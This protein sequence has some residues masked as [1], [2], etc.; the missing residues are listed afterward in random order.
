MNIMKTCVYPGSFDPVTYGHLDIIVRAAKTFDK[1]IV[2]VGVNSSKKY[3]FS[4]QQ[5]IDMLRNNIKQTNVEVKEFSGLLADFAYE[6][7]VG[8]IIK[9]VRNNQDF[10]YERLLHDINLTQQAGIDTHILVADNKLSHVSSSAAKELCR[11]QGLVHDYVPLVVKENLEWALNNQYILG[12]TG[13]I[14]MGKSYV[15]GKIVDL[16]SMDAG[17]TFPVFNI[18]LDKVAH[19][20]YESNEPVHINLRENITKEFGMTSFDRKWLGEIV[21]NDSEKL[22]YL[23]SMVRIPILTQLRKRIKGL[24]GLILLNGALLVEGDYLSLCNN[25]V[26][27]VESTQ[28]QQN[29]N[30]KNRGLNDK[31]IE[32]RIQ[33]QFNTGEKYRAVKKAIAKDSHGS[34]ILYQNVLGDPYYRHITETL[35]NPLRNTIREKLQFMKID[36]YRSAKTD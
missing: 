28:E 27:I 35:L 1:V 3:T 29:I 4:T 34:L 9:G 7:N 13:E 2:A 15:S 23:N 32:R 18:D 16:F 31:Q 14:G 26:V 19:E 6:N 25:N 33:S 10:D 5:R 21:F 8:T 24:K 11:F 20:L 12:V 30:L 22:Q 36:V 17:F